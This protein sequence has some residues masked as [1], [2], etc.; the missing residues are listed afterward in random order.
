MP[1]RCTHFNTLLNDLWIL[2][3]LQEHIKISAGRTKDQDIY[4]HVKLIAHNH[5]KTRNRNIILTMCS[6]LIHVI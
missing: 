4:V 5:W 1:W 2:N 3:I 6:T